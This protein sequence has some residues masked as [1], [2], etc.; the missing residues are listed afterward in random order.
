MTTSAAMTGVLF[1]HEPVRWRRAAAQ[2]VVVL[3]FTLVAAPSSWRPSRI[4]LI[5]DHAVVSLELA[6]TRA[7]CGTPST[8]S[9]AASI[10]PAL[11]TDAALRI[12]SLPSVLAEKAGS[13]S[14]F[15]AASTQT[16]VNN[17]NTVM[18]VE[19]ALLRLRPNMSMAQLGS[20]LHAVRIA[21]LAA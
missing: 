17:E 10:A 5:D 18:L 3:L 11:R 4:E 2:L 21:M 20:A 1:W 13:M 16:F 15:C 19:S 9:T 6:L 14:A 12:E 8:I 7:Y